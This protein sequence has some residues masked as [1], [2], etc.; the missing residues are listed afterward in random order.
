MKWTGCQWKAVHKSWLGVSS[1]TLHERFQ[2]W[3]QA[4]VFLKLMMLMLRLYGRRRGVQWLWQAIDSKSCPAPLGGDDTGKSP[5]DRGKRGSK[6]HRLVDQD[7][8][9][10]AVRL[11]GANVHDQWLA[12][13]LIVSIVVPRPD[14]DEVEQPLCMDQG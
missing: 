8:A 11:S 1:S 5:V 12:D 14:P 9:P 13:A 10:L 6:L 3:Q 4:G 7:R 2:E